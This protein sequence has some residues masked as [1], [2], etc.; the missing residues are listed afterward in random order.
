MCDLSLIVKKKSRCV[1]HL[2]G[3]KYKKT[4][5]HRHSSGL[6]CFWPNKCLTQLET[7]VL[8]VGNIK[9][10]LSMVEFFYRVLRPYKDWS[11]S[12]FPL[13]KTETIFHLIKLKSSCKCK[14]SSCKCL[15]KN[16]SCIF[17]PP[18]HFLQLFSSII[19]SMLQM[20]LIKLNLYLT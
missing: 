5:V 2:L 20:Q 15:C 12:F 16:T 13:R 3:Q 1:K 7:C 9:Y 18:K 11:T 14:M 17:Y 4:S 19:D 10:Y 8:E 6:L